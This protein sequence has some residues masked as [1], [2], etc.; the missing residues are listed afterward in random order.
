MHKNQSSD[1]SVI[2]VTPVSKVEVKVS[3]SLHATTNQ[4][5]IFTLDELSYALCLNAV[6]KVI[7]AIEI[8]L[9][10][11]APEIIIGIINVKGRII[12]VID[13]RRLFGLP[14]HDIDINDRIIIANAGNKQ[15]AIRVDS[16][17]GLMA[18][19]ERQM[20][21]E[22]EMLPK[23][24]HLRGIAKVD[25]GLILIYN[26]NQFLNPEEENELEQALNYQNN[27]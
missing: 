2:A 22:G 5:V 9:L 20:V 11:K 19:P 18:M 25:E 23:A 17:T 15:V 1:E 6:V 24:Q 8:R 14:A 12:P 26:L 16:V 10:P 27:E 3:E 13:I 7:H 4:I 21:P